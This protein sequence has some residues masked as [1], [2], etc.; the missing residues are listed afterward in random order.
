MEWVGAM[1]E[2]KHTC[3]TCMCSINYDH[4]LYAI[5]HSLSALACSFVHNKSA[6]CAC[7]DAKGD[8][9]TIPSAYDAIEALSVSDASI[10]SIVSGRAVT[11]AMNSAG[12]SIGGGKLSLHKS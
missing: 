9:V 1:C 5:K 4:P 7:T 2:L 3:T 8:Y 11:A 12:A 10:S 6:V